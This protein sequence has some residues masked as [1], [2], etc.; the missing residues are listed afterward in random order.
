M[1]GHAH[2]RRGE[3]TGG[4][5]GQGR[6]PSGVVRVDGVDHDRAVVRSHRRGRQGRGQA[7]R[8]AR[9]PR[10]QVPDRRARSVVPHLA[11]P[12]GRPPG[13]SVAH[14]GSRR[15]RLLH[16]LGR[17]R[18]GRSPLQRAHPPLPVLA[19]RRTGPGAFRRARRRRRT[20]RGQCVGGDRRPGDVGAGQLHDGD[21][22]QPAE[23]RPGRPRHR[24]D[25]TEALLR[26]CRLARRGGEVRLTAPGRVRRTGWRGLA[27]PDRRDVER[28]V[29]G[30]VRARWRRATVPLSRRRRPGGHAARR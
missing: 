30:A 24:S 7:A 13:L 10:D 8:V 12:A 27:R 6:R 2:R 19:L 3:P 20:R 23:P 18:R 9:V 11:A 1:A 17:T 21:R 29:P 22:P 15:R 5:G 16:R 25:A 28:G 14:E 4:N 26:R